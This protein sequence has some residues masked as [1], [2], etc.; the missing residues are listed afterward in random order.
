M[1]FHIEDAVYVPRYYGYGGKGEYGDRESLARHIERE[2]MELAPDTVLVLVKASPE[3]IKDRMRTS[4]HDRTVLKEEDVEEA[5]ELFEYHF[6]HSLLRNRITLDTSSSTVEETM[7][8]FT[9][10][11]GPYL[12]D[13][14][15]LRMQAHRSLLS[16]TQ[17]AE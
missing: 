7:R 9:D 1:G 11:I 17:P 10:Q 12:T 13:S 2:I 16:E 8:E 6:R 14:D 15:R 5:L 3:V 4:P